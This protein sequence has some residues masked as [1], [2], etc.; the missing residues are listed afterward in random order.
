MRLTQ[1]YKSRCKLLIALMSGLKELKEDEASDGVCLV[2]NNADDIHESSRDVLSFRCQSFQAGDGAIRG[3]EDHTISA[4]VDSANLSSRQ[5]SS[6]E[7]M[8]DQVVAKAIDLEMEISSGQLLSFDRTIEDD[9]RNDCKCNFNAIANE[10]VCMVAEVD[11]SVLESKLYVDVIDTDCETSPHFVSDEM[12]LLKYSRNTIFEDI[13]VIDNL[14][15]IKI[16]NCYD[17]ESYCGSKSQLLMED[18][19]VAVDATAKSSRLGPSDFGALTDLMPNLEHISQVGDDT[20]PEAAAIDAGGVCLEGQAFLV[21]DVEKSSESDNDDIMQSSLI[22]IEVR[23]SVS[24]RSDLVSR[25][26]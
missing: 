17:H 7:I 20:A 11:S 18:V 8:R 10:T 25:P 16:S 9:F 24:S 4:L 23:K 6:D 12:P 3:D 19:E 26:S 1:P 14:K 22:N 2:E 15:D 21:K 13:D 5:S